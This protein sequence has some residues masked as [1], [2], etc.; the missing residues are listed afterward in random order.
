[1][2]LT[3]AHA[4]VLWPDAKDLA[5]DPGDDRAEW[6]GIFRNATCPCCRLDFA[7]G[8][9]DLS[10]WAVNPAPPAHGQP[11]MRPRRRTGRPW[12]RSGGVRPR[13]A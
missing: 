12:I 3:A 8:E 11:R 6:E 7:A 1:V 13:A 2:P 5:A 9:A 4:E 10:A